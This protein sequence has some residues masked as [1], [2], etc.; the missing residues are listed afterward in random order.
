MLRRMSDP[1]QAPP[2]AAGDD[3]IR[4]PGDAANP[5]TE[6]GMT[7]GAAIAEASLAGAAPVVAETLPP[8]DAAP[9]LP[10]AA[11]RGLFVWLVVLAVGGALGLITDHGDL[12]VMFALAGLYVA[13]RAADRDPRWYLFHLAV[14]WIVPV[15]GLLGSIGLIAYARTSESTQAPIAWLVTTCAMAGFVSLV[16]L[17]PIFTHQL[18][19]MLFRTPHTTRV[20]RLTARLVLLS[21]ALAPALMLLWPD[22][23][24]LILERGETLADAS[25]LIT[26]LA[27]QVVLALAAIGLGIDRTWRSSL[28]RL[29][30]ERMRGSHWLVAAVG[31]A[32]LAGLNS[33]LEAA[34]GRW[35]PALAAADK[36]TVDWMVRD[37]S[38]ALA[39]VLGLCAGVGEE[40]S[41]RGAL[42]PRLGLVQ[43]SLVFAMLH[44]QYTWFGIAT[45]ALIGLLLGLIRSRTNTTT[46]MVIH[47]AYDVLV[48]VTTR[49]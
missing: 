31:L 8:V 39:L 33:G 10:D 3:S 14:Q 37:L 41:I 1:N 11:R 7:D 46:A 4:S 23:M 42:Q 16:L 44:I 40:V 43:S 45:V 19:V 20:L 21:L 9:A 32:A 30:L 49:H 26:G 22:L 38:P 15:S 17:I 2:G 24:R 13:A 48:A 36:A 35:F 18:A 47:V 6:A 29:G 25:A 5:P 12:A 27:G 34:E 28:E